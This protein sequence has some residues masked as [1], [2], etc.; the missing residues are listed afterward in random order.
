MS[1][2]NDDDIDF[3]NM[4]N[5][6]NNT[7]DIEDNDSTPE[8][9][10]MNMLRNNNNTHNIEKN[11][12]RTD[13]NDMFR[14]HISDIEHNTRNNNNLRNGNLRNGNTRTCNTIGDVINS[15]ITNPTD[16]FT[17]NNVN[18]TELPSIMNTFSDIKTIHMINCSLDN[19]RNLPPNV[20]NIDISHNNIT[21]VF[22]N[23]IPET[24]TEINLNKNNIRLLDL[25]MSINIKKLNIS[26]NPLVNVIALPYNII[27]L[28]LSFS[29]ITTVEC[30]KN[31]TNLQILKL[32]NTNISNI[33]NLPDSITELTIS[34]I[35]LYICNG[36][37]SNLPNSLTKLIAH[38]AGIKRFDFAVF[39]S[40]LSELDLYDNNLTELPKVPDKMTDIDISKNKLTRITNI[41]NFIEKFDS[42]MNKNLV[43]T[44]EQKETIR[45][46]KEIHWSNDI[47][48]DETYNPNDEN[49][50]N[51]VENKQR[52]IQSNIQNNKSNNNL[53]DSMMSMRDNMR[54][55]VNDMQH[56]NRYFTNNNQ[57]NIIFR[58]T[59]NTNFKP[60]INPTHKIRHRK[61]Y[62][63]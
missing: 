47:L 52:D 24:V 41:P 3:M 61:I 7:S 45:K 8:D 58:M 32:N 56:H 40:K 14:R 16:T 42:Q 33:N 51:F 21:E 15:Y 54:I 60:S 23:N 27:E 13:S 9:L 2:S 10:M 25:S 39:P 48:I 53:F 38:S 59:Q 63:V 20:K 19:L 17:S 26:N 55:D 62:R 35:N 36:I 43:Y 49:I 11:S 34:R 46:L 5:H 31:L 18:I 1:D 44:L 37:I 6:D 22:S 50:F 29:S 57:Q 30:L 28:D 12:S 4:M